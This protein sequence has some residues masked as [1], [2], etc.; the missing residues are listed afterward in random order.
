MKKII[1]VILVLVLVLGFIPTATSSA[2]YVVR[3]SDLN[4]FS[5][6]ALNDFSAAGHAR[7]S[8]WVGGTL[9]NNG[10]MNVDDGSVGGIGAGTSYIYN[11]QSS[12]VFKAR[13]G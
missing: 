13:S 10:D 8:I 2:D 12:I 11:N 4:N 3:L 9:T 7:G 5:I 6:V 1:A